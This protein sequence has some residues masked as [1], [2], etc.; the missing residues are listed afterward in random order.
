MGYG[1]N[2]KVVPTDLK[3]HLI[4]KLKENNIKYDYIDFANSGHGLLNDLD[5]SE[6]FYKR[7]DEYL[8]KYFENK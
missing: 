7:V 2:D 3:Y 8:D 1:P 6:E 4:D 5:K